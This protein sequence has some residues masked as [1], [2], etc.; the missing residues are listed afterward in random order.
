VVS[1]KNLYGT[2]LNRAGVDS[3]VPSWFDIDQRGEALAETYGIDASDLQNYLDEIP[4]DMSHFFE[5]RR[6]LYTNN[7]VG[8]QWYDSGE[9]IGDEDALQR[10]DEVVNNLETSDT[11]E[12]TE[13]VSD[14]VADRLEQLGYVQG[15]SSE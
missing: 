5:L 15:N 3:D 13:K 12:H 9:V 1:L 8:E 14:E 10:L 2:L 6:R 4:D 11:T 7:A